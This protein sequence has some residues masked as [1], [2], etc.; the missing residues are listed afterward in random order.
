MRV[1]ASHVG[2]HAFFAISNWCMN[3]VLPR[4]CCDRLSYCCLHLYVTFVAHLRRHKLRP[5]DKSRQN[6]RGNLIGIT[7]ILRNCLNIQYN[8]SIRFITSQSLK[9]RFLLYFFPEILIF[10]KLSY[11]FICFILYLLYLSIS[12]LFVDS[13]SIQSN[14]LTYGARYAEKSVYSQDSHTL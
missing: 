9:Y 3:V 8:R 12:S 7:N 6:E 2:T 11:Y 4:F 1:L 5:A 10:T 13:K 14:R